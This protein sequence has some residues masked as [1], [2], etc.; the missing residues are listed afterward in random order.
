V[1]DLHALVRGA[2]N[3]ARTMLIERGEPEVT[4]M[5]HLVA[6]AGGTDAVII[7]PW[8]DAT[9]GEATVVQTWQIVRAKPGGRVLALIEGKGMAGDF[10]GRLVDGLI[11]AKG[12]R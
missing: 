5:Y 3:L 12:R 9:D 7:C 10:Q 11:A 4:G 8:R 1:T 2:G 6:P